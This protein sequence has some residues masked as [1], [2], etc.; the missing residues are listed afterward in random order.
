MALLLTFILF[1][2]IVSFLCSILEAVLLS[3]SPSYIAAASKKGHKDGVL[4]KYYKTD[5]DRPLAAILSLNTIAHTVGAAG[6][7]AQA[8]N[9]FGDAYFGIASALLT[10]LILVFSEIIPKTLGALYWRQLAP[11]CGQ[12]LRLVVWSM[13]PFIGFSRMITRLMTRKS[14]QR[15]VKREEFVALAELGVQ[16]G[17]LAP[18]ESKV[19][20]SLMRFHSLTIRDIMTPRQ[21]VFSLPQSAT[22]HEAIELNGPLRFSRIPVYAEHNDDIVGF[23]RK[24][25]LL[26]AAI[27]SPPATQLA[28]LK[29]EILTVPETLSL[30]ILLR[31]IVE[32]G[33]QIMLVVNEYGDTKG[34][35]T[36]E[37]LIET[38]IGMEIVDET[39]TVTDMRLLAREL[40]LK[41]AAELG[42]DPEA[43]D[44]ES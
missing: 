11:V 37:D 35:V 6:A 26:L 9:V 8:V 24:D 1:A 30:A 17:V 14:K 16:E 3:I 28:A 21:V 33:D 38:M 13:Y 12:L 25:D 19:L 7:G 10:L 5:I 27:K 43:V 20:R 44:Q 32:S 34:I 2:L 40:W 42:I 41:R 36:M 23:V 4:W 39:D 15:S 31:R 18:E 29:R 22:V